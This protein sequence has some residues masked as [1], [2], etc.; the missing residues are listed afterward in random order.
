MPEIYIFGGCNGS[1]KT[2]FA[3]TFLSALPGVEFVNADI[4]AAELNPQDVDT[5]AFQASRLMLER[6]KSLSDR[7]AD[8]AFESTLATRSFARFLRKC[9][10]KGY[11]IN[12]VYIWLESSELAVAR[13]ARRVESGGHNI[14]TNTIIRRYERGRTNFIELY[15]PIADRWIVYD[16]SYQ[17]Q[18]IAETSLNQ[19]LTIYQPQIWQEIISN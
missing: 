19:T 3:T 13:V 4:I 10:G 12:L 2:T 7:N 14:P 6:L 9:K 17:T 15:L 1:G 11:T 5:V 18:K 8:F 16:N